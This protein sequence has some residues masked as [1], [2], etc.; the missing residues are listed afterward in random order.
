MIRLLYENV[1]D[2]LLRDILKKISDFLNSVDL[3]KADFK[4]YEY[5]F[6]AAVTNLKIPHSLGKIPRDVIVTAVTDNMVVTWNYDEFTNSRL[7]V[8][9]DKAGTVR[10][11]IGTFVGG[12]NV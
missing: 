9:T 12:N 2:P 7:D 6:S 10:Y 4:F 3:L 1:V 8:T 5:T 11:F